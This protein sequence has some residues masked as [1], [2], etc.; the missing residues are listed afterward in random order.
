M[1]NYSNMEADNAASLYADVQGR[2]DD[3][4][5]YIEERVD[6]DIK[7]LKEYGRTVDGT[8]FDDLLDAINMNFAS[9]WM[10]DYYCLTWD[11][12]KKLATMKRYEKEA[13]EAIRKHLYEKY[14]DE[15]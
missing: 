10:H 1:P 4:E 5:A 12:E 9:E 3:K 14:E 8:H 6:E 2:E 13:L 7:Y 11:D 15:L